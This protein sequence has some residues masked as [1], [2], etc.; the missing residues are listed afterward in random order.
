MSQGP[1]PP[2]AEVSCVGLEPSVYR[3]GAGALA[4]DPR[5][6]PIAVG[7]SDRP[8]QLLIEAAPLRAAGERLDLS[9][10]QWPGGAVSAAFVRLQASLAMVRLWMVASLYPG[11]TLHLKIVLVLDFY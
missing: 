2:S 1:C 7:W 10:A 4:G 6:R 3:V 5:G 8:R 11:L 9:G